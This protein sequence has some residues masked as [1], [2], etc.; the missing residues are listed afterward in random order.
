M[1]QNGPGAEIWSQMETTTSTE[2]DIFSRKKVYKQGRRN[3]FQNVIIPNNLSDELIPVQYVQT[4]SGQSWDEANLVYT[5][6]TDQSWIAV[7]IN[8]AKIGFILN[9]EDYQHWNDSYLDIW[10]RS[11]YVCIC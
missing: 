1:S 10:A 11:K 6:N 7:S 3:T 9:A 5:M 2:I 8:M 4:F